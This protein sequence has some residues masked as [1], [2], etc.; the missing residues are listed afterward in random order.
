MSAKCG[1]KRG[2]KRA[3]DG[4]QLGFDS[5]GR[6]ATKGAAGIG[7]GAGW[8]YR[9]RRGVESVENAI[10]WGQ[11]DDFKVNKPGRYFSDGEAQLG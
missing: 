3:K 1:P 7:V 11:K 8:R 6:R 9:E 4:A 5:S 10:L 2:P